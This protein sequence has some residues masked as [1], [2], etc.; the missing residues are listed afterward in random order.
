MTYGT[1][2]HSACQEA[3]EQDDP[4]LLAIG[5][6]SERQVKTLPATAVSAA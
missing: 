6:L 5:C 4:G 1:G 2:S 3:A